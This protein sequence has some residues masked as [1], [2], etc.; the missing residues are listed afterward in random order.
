MD[1]KGIIDA[2]LDEV[3]QDQVED[4]DKILIKLGLKQV[5]KTERK[6]KKAKFKGEL[7]TYNLKVLFTCKLCKQSYQQVF[8]MEVSPDG[9]QRIGRK[10]KDEVY[11]HKTRI[12][13]VN[14]CAGCKASLGELTREQ[15]IDKILELAKCI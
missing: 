9:C 2:L 14:F 15:L 6:P 8:V 12:E 13:K 3:T 4:L 10:V 11:C 7:I 1:D 5:P